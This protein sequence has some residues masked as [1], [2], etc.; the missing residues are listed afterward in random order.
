MVERW[1][2]SEQTQPNNQKEVYV[3]LQ[4]AA[5]FHYLVEEW[6]DCEELTPK[7]K[8][9]RVFRRQENGSHEA[10]HGVLRSFEYTALHEVRK[11]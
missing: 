2:K 7:S 9:Q 1:R 3:A 4:Q 10:S 8:G 6:H 5:S 11:E